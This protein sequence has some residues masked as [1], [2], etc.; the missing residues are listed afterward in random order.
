M[1]KLKPRSNN[2][3][4]MARDYESLLQAMRDL[5]PEKLDKEWTDYESEADFGNV[6]LQLFAH[7][8]DILSYYQDRIANESF[9]GT[10]Q[11]RRSIIHHLK[12]IG[13]RLATAA[14]A[15]VSLTVYVPVECTETITIEKGN[16][17][18]TTSQDDKPSVRF[19]YT[20]DVP[21]TI[22]CEKLQKDEKKET[23]K[24]FEISVE[25]GYL[26]QNEILG[27][28]DG[29]KNQTFTL[30]HSQVILRSLGQGQSTNKDITLLV[31]KRQS[32]GLVNNKQEWTLRDNL[33][34]SREQQTD[35]S[36]E[37]DEND[38]ATVVFGDGEYGAIPDKNDEIMV[39][40]RIGG[41]KQGNVAAGAIDTIIDAPQL[42]LLG[43][44][45]KNLKAATGGSERETIQH[46]VQQ[47]PAV[48]RSLKRAVTEEDYEKLALKY[49]GVG[50]VRVEPGHWNTVTLHIAPEGGGAVSDILKHNLLAYFEDK[51]P[52]TTL[53]QI[54]DVEYVEIYVTA[55]IG[56]EKY[57]DEKEVKTQVEQ[58]AGQLLAFE[59]VDFG[60]TLYLSKFYE[61]IET[62]AGVKHVYLAEFRRERPIS[63]IMAKLESVKLEKLEGFVQAS[64]KLTL[65]KPEKLEN[66]S[67]TEEEQEK[68]IEVVTRINITS[69]LQ[70]V[71]N[72]EK[73]ESEIKS[74]LNHHLESNKEDYFLKQVSNSNL[75]NSKELRIEDKTQSIE[76]YNKWNISSE[77]N[78][79]LTKVNIQT[80]KILIAF[81]IAFEVRD[82]HERK[83]ETIEYRREVKIT[84]DIMAT[85]KVNPTISPDKLK[86]KV[87]KRLKKLNIDASRELKNNPI[88]YKQEQLR[89]RFKEQLRQRFKQAIQ[90]SNDIE[91]TNIIV[92]KKGDQVIPLIDTDGQINFTPKELPKKPDD[93]DYSKGIQVIVV[94]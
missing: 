48:F 69:D 46:A 24:K 65:K 18:A 75:L 32:D 35:F 19:E 49:P 60:K 66:S 89:Q 50:K 17:F 47:A 58:A 22:N 4:Y 20:R 36:I 7:M 41:G 62:V 87:M 10:A 26:V 34:F 86:D 74:K 40:Y 79:N 91:V 42:T 14:P 82:I 9:L 92:N 59:K 88:D 45:V 57:Y 39:N 84:Y 12:L 15:S 55:R 44:T 56:V 3:D 11:N 73:L 77:L 85:I 38:Y 61:A 13:Y 28:S 94:E 52:V 71:I 30:A 72:G 78:S 68:I 2:I 93:S 6:L 43:A 51:R 67:T 76:S 33:A 37:V 29:T 80:G 81:D 31:I 23:L 27:S 16:A 83:G 21:L 53:I 8:G 63:K 90:D 25:E 70:T 54:E 5:I 1:T 64:F